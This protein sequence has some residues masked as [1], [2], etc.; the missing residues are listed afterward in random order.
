ML[1]DAGIARLIADGFLSPYHHYTIPRY[2]PEAVAAQLIGDPA[3][4][5]RSLVFFH[6]HDQ[7]ADLVARLRAADIACD[8]VTASTPRERQLAAFEAGETRVLVNMAIL[9]EGFDCPA[10]QTVF[11]RPSGKGCTI[12]MAGRVLRRA[13]ELPFKQIVQCSQTRHPMLKTAPAAEQYLLDPDGRWRSVA[14]N[15]QLDEIA[16]RSMARI[17]RT[18]V[19]LPR[20]CAPTARDPPALARPCRG[21]LTPFMGGARPGAGHPNVRTGAMASSR[22]DV[23]PPAARPCAHSSP[24]R[25]RLDTA[26]PAPDASPP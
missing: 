23:R 10:L 16:R 3:R 9:V 4:W 13:P 14:A 11:C 2:T 17:A 15:R 1:S 6:R 26:A 8:L 21:R 19:E 5:G 20:W 18:R 24:T 7:C 22:S 12:Q 25:E